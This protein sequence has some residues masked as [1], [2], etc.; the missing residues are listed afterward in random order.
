[1]G[2]EPGEGGEGAVRV[3]HVVEDDDGV[4][5]GGGARE[6][7]GEEGEGVGRE[8]EGGGEIGEAG[9]AGVGGG[10]AEEGTVGAVG[11]DPYGVLEW[12][13]GRGRGVFMEGYP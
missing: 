9:V 3:G 1:M 12:G 5:L 4:L 13:R 10:A 11:V 2:S 7:E 6:G 8:V